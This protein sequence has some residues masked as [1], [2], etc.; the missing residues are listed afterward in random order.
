MKKSILLFALCL[1]IF[2]TLNAQ[3]TKIGGG[4]TFSSGFP[5]HHQPWD[6]NKS[7]LL[8]VN[9]KGI[10]EISVPLHVSPTITIFYPHITKETT[11]KT[12]VSSI[13]FDING[14]YV[15]NSLDQFEFYGLAGLDVLYATKKE[16]YEGSSTFKESDNALGLNLGVGTYMKITEQFDLYGE[17]KYIFSSYD[18]FMINAGILLNLDWLKKN[19]TPGI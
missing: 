19:E 16:A 13:M 18:Q 15:F 7:G 1:A 10:Y 3:F 2:T 4:L 14:H 17:A 5:F 11:M 12:T 6:A 8:A 9:L